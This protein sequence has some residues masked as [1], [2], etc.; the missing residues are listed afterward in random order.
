M[1]LG[2]L[3]SLLLYLKRVVWTVRYSSCLRRPRALRQ[4]GTVVAGYAA[5]V[6]ATPLERS[7]GLRLHGV[8]AQ[9]RTR[10]YQRTVTTFVRGRLDPAWFGVARLPGA[11]NSFLLDAP[12]AMWVWHSREY[13]YLLISSCRSHYHIVNMVS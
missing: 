8:G 2:I 4:A 5:V 12:T 9:P 3:K 7:G 6:L 1:H 10:P 13:G 11:H